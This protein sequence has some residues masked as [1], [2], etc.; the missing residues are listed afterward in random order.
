M[1][2]H[3]SPNEWTLMEQ[4]WRA[5]P[6]TITQLTAALQPQ[7]GWSKHTVIT[8]LNRLQD[9]GAV[10]YRDGGRARLYSACIPRAQAAMEET[11]TLLHRV[12]GGSIGLLVNAFVQQNGISAAERAELLAILQKAGEDA[13]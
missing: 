10:A 2:I 3:F 1:S 8:M 11:E 5:A 4:L 7:A 6:Q 13:P 12:Y 9:K